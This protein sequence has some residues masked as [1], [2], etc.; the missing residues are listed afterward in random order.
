[1]SR[2]M[3]FKGK[4]SAEKRAYIKLSGTWRSSN[5]KEV[6]KECNVSLASV[7]R[8][9]KAKIYKDKQEEKTS[10]R[11]GRPH[12]LSLRQKRSLLRNIN[13]L[14]EENSNFTTKK[15]MTRS[16]ISAKEISSRTVRRCLNNNGYHYLQARKKG[17]LNV[18]DIKRRCMFAKKMLKEFSAVVWTDKIAF[19]LDGV[20]FTHKRN[21]ADEAKA[22]K[23]RIWRRANEALDRNCTAKGSHEGT[24]GKL[25][26][27]MVAITYRQGV[28]LCDQYDKLDGQYFSEL[29][30]REFNRMFME[31]RKGRS[32][33]WLQDGDPSQNSASAKEA[34]KSVRAQLLSIPAR[35]PDLNPIENFFHLIKRKLN[36]DAIEQNI[37]KESFHEFSARVKRTI[38]NF[39]KVK[40]DR[41]IESMDKRIHMIKAKKGKRIKY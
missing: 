40:I 27:A 35:S 19:Y 5:A 38:L 15:L 7:Y 18:R 13:K 9:W 2:E 3:A 22:P 25:V 26:K 24:G 10:N 29:I 30:L 28:V 17:V 33:L 31:A 8:V 16:G 20:S 1:M 14:R 37:T 12:K 4:I 34:M 6:A 36:N 23:G 21:P 11:G 41:I 39:D 32:R